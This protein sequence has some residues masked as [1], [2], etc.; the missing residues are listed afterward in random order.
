MAAIEALVKFCWGLLYVVD[1]PGPKSCG[2]E[3]FKFSENILPLVCKPC[4]ND[5]GIPYGIDL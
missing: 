2:N 5:D 1:T 4:I 3:T